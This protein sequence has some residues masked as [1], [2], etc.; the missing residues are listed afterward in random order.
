MALAFRCGWGYAWRMDFISVVILLVIIMDPIGLAPVI[1]GLLKGFAPRDR[2]R[3]LLREQFFALAI[4]LIF[5]VFGNTLLNFLQLDQSTLN[6]SGGVLLFMV[7]IGMVFPG[8]SLMHPVRDN[9]KA[10]PFIVPIAVPLIAGPSTIAVVLLRSGQVSQTG[11][12]WLLA[13]AIVTAWL[14]TS[15]LMLLSQY[16]IKFLGDRGA[17]AMERLMGM[18]LILI[19]VQMF[20]DG[21]KSYGS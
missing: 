16:I 17:I 1:P 11:E 13:G 3:I 9:A 14:I 18:L 6:I 15:V 4:L 12:F 10:D 20:L 2:V 7:A 8:I 19:S 21:L 5:L